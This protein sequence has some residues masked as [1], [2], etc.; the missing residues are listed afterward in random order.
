MKP[1]SPFRRVQTFP[2]LDPLNTLLHTPPLTTE[3]RLMHIQALGQR[4]NGYVRFMCAVGTLESC[5]GEAKQNAV[6]VFY[7]C[8]ATLEPPLGRVPKKL[9]RRSRAAG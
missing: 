7:D 5:S 6:N 1:K 2:E 9:Q 3:D 4:I 8:L